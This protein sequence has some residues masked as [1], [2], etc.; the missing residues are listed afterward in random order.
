LKSDFGINK[1]IQDCKIGT[2][3][4]FWGVLVGRGRVNGGDGGE[5]IWLMGFRNLHEIEQ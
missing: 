4:V 1:E 5:G 3:C 2:A